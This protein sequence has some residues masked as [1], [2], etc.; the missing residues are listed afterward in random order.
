MCRVSA[1]GPE[2]P[3]ALAVL[4]VLKSP[5]SERLQQRIVLHAAPEDVDEAR[6]SL[7]PECRQPT[8]LPVL[9]ILR[10]IQ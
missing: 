4:I 5:A 9:H 2:K 10:V 8:K 7:G 6:S 1:A 3:E